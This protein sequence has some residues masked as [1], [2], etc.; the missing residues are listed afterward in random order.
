M[1]HALS[2]ALVIWMICVASDARAEASNMREP[3]TGT[4]FQVRRNLGG[5]DHVLVGVGA[6]EVT[7]LK[8][9]VYGA[10]MYVGIKRGVSVWQSYL[11]GRF[12]KAG[13]VSAGQPDF[14]KLKNASAAY[15]FMIYGRFPKAVD[16]EFVRNA[17]ADKFVEAYNEN[18]DRLKVDRSK[19]GAPLT[20]FMEA[21]N[22]SASKG[23]H[24]MIR[25]SGSNIWLSLPGGGTK[26]IK[27]NAYFVTALWR[28]YFANPCPQRGLR[29]GLLS[30]LDR[31]HALASGS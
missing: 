19:A 8:I 28:I 1:Q 16:M 27:G 18:W 17:D 2:S 3:E 29:E 20:Q 22:H 15:H 30:K 21:I 26:H 6:R 13:L 9:N 5:V 25:T 4:S 24:M 23:D 11:S 14:T 12:A 31:L 7:A 10:G